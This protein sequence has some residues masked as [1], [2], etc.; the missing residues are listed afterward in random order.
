MSTKRVKCPKDY[1]EYDTSTDIKNFIK[2][3]PV[4]NVNSKVEDMDLFSDELPNILEVVSGGSKNSEEAWIMLEKFRNDEDFF[5]E[6]VKEYYACGGF[7]INICK[8]V[9]INHILTLDLYKQYD[10]FV[11]CGKKHIITLKDTDY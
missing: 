6:S 2:L 3:Y 9:K 5:K 4:T 1:I 7:D 11:F 10:V 8:N